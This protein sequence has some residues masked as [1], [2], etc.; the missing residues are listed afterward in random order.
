MRDFDRYQQDY[1]A[2]PFEPVQA[3]FRRRR[4]IEHLRRLAPASILEVGCGEQPLFLDYRDFAR[5]HVV[6]PGARFLASAR[7]AAAGRTDVL[8]HAGTLEEVAP[9]LQDLRFDCIVLSSVLHEC[10]DPEA[11][12]R[13]VFGLCSAGTAVHVYV[14]NADSL[15]RR[16]ALA[17]GLTSSLHEL[18]AIQRQMQQHVTYDAASLTARL[19]A[20]GFVVQETGSFFIKPFTHAQMAR[21]QECGFLDER[22]L[23]GLYRLGD[24]TPGLGSELFAIATTG[25]P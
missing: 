20:A 22:M 1:A 10:P 18:S 11:F 19:Q 7:A 15:H 9:Q 16:L 5:M 14:P 12:L 21:L 23:E 25:R 24:T 4:V 2:L 6:E 13:T 3:A 17:M 8:L